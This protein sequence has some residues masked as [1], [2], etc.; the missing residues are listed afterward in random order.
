MVTGA[1]A[2]I[3]YFVAEQLA[4]AGAAVVLGCRDPGKAEL[5]MTSIRSRVPGAVLRPVPLDLVDLSSL[6]AAAAALSGDRL[7]GVV[8]NAGVL[9][10][11]PRLRGAGAE[12]IS[13]VAHPGGALDPLSPARPPLFA[14][15]D[16]ERLRGLPAR[17]VL[18]GKHAGARPIVRALLGSD[19]SG[20]QLWGPRVA[21]LRGHPHPE[22]PHAHMTDPDTA[23]RLWRASAA[24]AGLGPGPW[25]R[26]RCDRA[27]TPP[28][29]T[30][31]GSE[32]W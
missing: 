14:P 15:T 16:A 1:S 25:D 9:S 20:G 22:S 23:A 13:V 3:G 4:T 19:V 17:A 32:R 7:D 18:H 26:G 8:L 12:V 27:H 29:G 5:A 2:G 28:V 24:L 21:G 6:P 31:T 30:I 11:G 10:S